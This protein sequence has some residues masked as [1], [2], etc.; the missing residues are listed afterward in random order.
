MTQKR[1]YRVL[2]VDDHDVVRSGIRALLESQIDIEIWGEAANATEAIVK[3]KSGKP[4]LVLLDLTLPKMNGLDVMRTILEFSPRP[5]VLILSMHC[6]VF[7]ARE[8]L[9]AG[10]RGYVLKSDANSE[11]LMA[12]EHL[13]QGKP[14]FSRQ[15][16][17]A[18][19]EKIQLDPDSEAESIV[20]EPRL[21]PR[22]IEVLRMLAEGNGNKQV[23]AGLGIS[24]RTVE[25]HRDHIMHKL[26]LSNFSELIRFAIRHHLVAG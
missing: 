1:P 24:R 20:R 19:A 22:E 4:D 6:S 5:E 18:M 21:S 9:R 25:A 8:A 3:V 23:A 14:Y 26:K 12:L 11:L 2:I 15:L 7:I 10:A 16:A 13:R 17:A